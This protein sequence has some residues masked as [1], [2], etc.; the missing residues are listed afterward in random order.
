MRWGLAYLVNAADL[1]AD[2]ACLQWILAEAAAGEGDTSQVES[3]VL[4]CRQRSK[5]TCSVGCRGGFHVLAQAAAV[6]EGKVSYVQ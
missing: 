6:A 2:T 3:R 4:S 1:Q 5:A